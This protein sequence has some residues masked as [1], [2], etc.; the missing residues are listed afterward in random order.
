MEHGVHDDGAEV[1][2]PSKVVRRSWL[3]NLLFPWEERTQISFVY[4]A[5]RVFNS[6]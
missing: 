6:L 5:E 3:S 4:W 1:E 2:D